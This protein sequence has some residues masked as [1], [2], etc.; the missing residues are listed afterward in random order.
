M[1]TPFLPHPLRSKGGVKALPPK[2]VDPTT[3]ATALS[4]VFENALLPTVGAAPMKVVLVRTV[5]RAKAAL[6]S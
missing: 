5:Q 6:P 3:K 4:G 1:T 2:E